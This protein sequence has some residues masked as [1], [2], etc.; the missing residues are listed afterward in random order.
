MNNKISNEYVTVA[1]ASQKTG[2]NQKQINKLK[3]TRRIGFD[4][5]SDGKLLVNL[6]HI[7]QYKAAHPIKDTVWDGIDY[8][9]GEKFYMLMGYDGK[10]FVSDKGRV[11]N[12]SSGQVLTPQ[13]RKKDC[14]KQVTLMQNGEEKAEYLHRLIAL[15]QCPNVLKKDIVHH[16]KLSDSAIDKASNLL[17]VWQHQHKE[18]HRLLRENKI[19]E[20]NKMI[21]EIKKENKQK[22]FEIPH[23]DYKSDE[24]FNYFLYVNKQGYTAYKMG[25]DVPSECIIFEFVQLVNK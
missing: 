7:M 21:K 12:A 9:A 22:V 8:Q 25:Q 4:H 16:I 18:L 6:K 3:E 23:P 17:W 19:E 20:Y 10:Y 24:H 14:Y 15:T 2:Y 13:T 11:I 5:T 1:E